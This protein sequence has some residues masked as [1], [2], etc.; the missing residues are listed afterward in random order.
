MVKQRRK[1]RI[2][3][4]I[5]TVLAICFVAAIISDAIKGKQLETKTEQLIEISEEYSDLQIEIANKLSE[6]VQL[7]NDLASLDTDIASLHAE[8]EI[9]KNEL[10]EYKEKSAKYFS[11]NYEIMDYEL[12]ILYKMVE[13]E[14]TGGKSDAKINVAHVI[15]NRVM[16]DRFPDTIIEVVFQER[17][18][19]PINDGRYYKVSITESTKSAVHAAINGLDTTEG[20]LFFMYRPESDLGNVSWF[21]RKLEYKFTD[22]I[23]HEFYSLK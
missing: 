4:V 8:L 12:E 16:S 22:S 21:D 20:S 9:T 1:Y 7:K 17:Q 10:Q 23:G 14:A 18:F 11:N 6:N 13:A 5:I 2:H 15:L 3:E 19:Q